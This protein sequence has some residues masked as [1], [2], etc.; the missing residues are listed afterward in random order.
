M[1]MPDKS[2]T[3]KRKAIVVAGM[4]R[5][6]TSALTKALNLVGAKLPKTLMKPS[7]NNP[8]GHWESDVL[9]QFNE[10]TLQ[11]LDSSWKDWRAT[12]KFANDD[13]AEAYVEDLVQ[14]LSDEFA[15]ADL[16]V[17]KDPRTCKLLP[18]WLD[19]LNRMD[20]EPYIVIP[21]RHP[22]EVAHSLQKRNRLPLSHGMLL[23][24]RYCL[25][26]ERDTREVARVF[27]RYEGLLTDWQAELN[28]I[29]TM[30]QDDRLAIDSASRQALNEFLSEEYRHH[31]ADNA[32]L[33]SGFVLR[34]VYEAYEALLGCC[35]RQ[36]TANAQPLLDGIYSQFD[37]LSLDIGD[38]C[39]QYLSIEKEKNDRISEVKGL[40]ENA[41]SYQ[42]ELSDNVW[43]KKEKIEVL[44]YK[45]DKA[46]SQRDAY[47]RK[48]QAIEAIIRE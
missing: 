48:L 3:H 37:E 15:E 33:S 22:L 20:V 19:A 10:S 8:Q 24:L 46:I 21:I 17:V 1:P 41:K 12:P 28:K 42:R 2:P 16:F 45:L 30:V 47:E 35:D 14:H 31:R 9:S 18:Y 25:E 34:W 26:A 29:M 6:G 27:T 36:D 13:E 38:M 4:H 32:D 11:R 40:L 39:Y 43:K 44:K 5:S 23:W 7:A